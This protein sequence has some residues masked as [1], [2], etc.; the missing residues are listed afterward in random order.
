MEPSDNER[1]QT[2]FSQLQSLFYL[3]SLIPAFLAIPVLCLNLTMK[4]LCRIKWNSHTFYDLKSEVSLVNFPCH[5]KE[6]LIYI[7]FLFTDLYFYVPPKFHIDI[8]ESSVARLNNFLLDS[9]IINIYLQNNMIY[10][11]LFILTV[12]FL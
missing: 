2:Q 9:M 3:W 1:T 6:K 10:F 11:S 12:Y 8:Q 7:K 5:L 4:D